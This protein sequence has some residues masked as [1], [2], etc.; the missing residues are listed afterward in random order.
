MI[1][2]ILAKLS[3]LLPVLPLLIVLFA[4]AAGIESP[5]LNVAAESVDHDQELDIPVEEKLQ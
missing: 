1:Y 3:H 5:R 2:P 4:L